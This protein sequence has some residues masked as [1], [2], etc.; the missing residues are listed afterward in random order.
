MYQKG[1]HTESRKL[2]QRGNNIRE[3]TQEELFQD[4][5]SQ[6]HKRNPLD[7]RHNQTI[8]PNR[9]CSCSLCLKDTGNVCL[10][11]HLRDKNFQKDTNKMVWLVPNSDKPNQ[12]HNFCS[13]KQL[14]HQYKHHIVHLNSSW[15]KILRLGNMPQQGKNDNP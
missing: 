10:V 5:R 11:E 12:H 13:M 7:K 1:K 6:L 4:C 3:G 9:T 2:F 14:D 15:D 8:A